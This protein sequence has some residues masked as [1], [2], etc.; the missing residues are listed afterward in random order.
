MPRHVRELRPHESARAFFGAELRHWRVRRHYSQDD[1]GRLTLHSGD[2]I[3]KVEKATRWPSEPLAQRCDLVL[4]TG[5]ELARLL[6]LVMAERSATGTRDGAGQLVTA[7]L[8]DPDVGAVARPA[9]Q[10]AVVDA[11]LDA[12]MAGCSAT[13]LVS[14]PGGFGKTT[15]A[16]QSCRDGRVVD[17]FNAL[18]WI[19]LG[20]DCG[21][22][23]ILQLAADL[24]ERLTR[25]RPVLSSTDQAG[26]TLAEALADRRILLVIDNV[27]T[28]NALA[29]FLLGGART[30]R[31]VTTRDVG[32]SRMPAA[33][34]AVPPMTDVQTA[35]LIS[36]GSV[37]P[38]R[39]AHALPTLA[40]A[41]RGWPLLASVLAGTVARDLTSGASEATAIDRALCALRDEGPEAFDVADA[42]R[43]EGTIGRVVMSSLGHLDDTLTFRGGESLSDRYL[44]LAIF[45][46]AVPIPVPVLASWWGAE[47]GWS[48]TAVRQFA[49][50]L[51]DRSLLDAYRAADDTLVLHDVFRACLTSRARR[52]AQDAHKS[53]VASARASAPGG[54]HDLDLT[55]PYLWRHLTHHLCEAG[56][57]EEVISLLSEPRYLITKLHAFGPTAFVDDVAALKLVTG[58]GEATEEHVA[59]TL[60]RAVQLATSTERPADTA[61]TMLVA[62]CW[63]G[64]L[65][66]P[67]ATELRSIDDRRF[68]VRWSRPREEH[69]D[70]HTGAITSVAVAANRI[71]SGGEDGT[72]RVWDRESGR[73][74]RVLRGHHGW[75]HAVT[76]SLPDD[77]VASAGDDHV[78]RLWTLSSGEPLGV[79]TGHG[80]RV[81]SLSIANG[82]RVLLSAG[83]DGAVTAWSVEQRAKL[84]DMSTPGRPLWAVDVDSTGAVVAAGGEDETVRLYDIAS[85]AL[86]AEADGHT[87]WVRTV[88][89]APDAPLLA[90]GSGDG[91]VCLWST[92][93]GSLTLLRRTRTRQ[94]VRSVALSPGGGVITSAGEAAQVDAVTAAGR[95]PCGE[96]PPTVD[97]IRSLA[98][99]DGEAV[100]GCEDGSIR[101]LRD[102]VSPAEPAV[103]SPGCGTVWSTAFGTSG[104]VAFLGHHDGRVQITRSGTGEVTSSFQVGTG[105]IWSLAATDDIVAAACGDGAVRVWD[106]AADTEVGTFTS[107]D[108][109]AWAV[110]VDPTGISLAVAS[111]TGTLSLWDMAT[112][113]LRW[114]TS[115]HTGRIR[116]LAFGPHGNTMVTGGAD[117]ATRVWDTA[118]GARTA[119][120]TAGSNWVRS[121]ALDRTGTRT[122]SGLGSGDITVRGVGDDT[123]PVHLFGHSGRIL[124][125][126]FVTDDRL[127]SAAADG[128]IRL[129]SISGQSQLAHVRVDASLQCAAIH[130]L[131]GSVLASSAT[132][133]VALDVMFGQE[134]T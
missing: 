12:G 131:T 88:A 95:V 25:E 96:L 93:N 97:W 129:W 132:G 23:R 37:A 49:R 128:T 80:K 74:V 90:S 60:L 77:L 27:W 103:F 10:E 33:T 59:A 118:T 22:G 99:H 112:R 73:L 133:V 26:F 19:E 41:C 20:P 104:H 62:L 101:L 122:A 134:G 13:V 121:V 7:W 35:Q 116:G 81:R 111:G 64:H 75:V 40:A 34:I 4:D 57:P 2:L 6:P 76:V 58:A 123:C 52:T 85:G 11:L 127:V 100:L 21:D 48:T 65:D 130:P 39:D 17:F 87:D 8:P 86:L 31:L 50:A 3:A 110:A 5:G 56:L 44:D 92:T 115:A 32:V 102:T 24:C 15:L 94:R 46:P 113:E 38:L 109:R 82:G 70:G 69:G 29:P 79:L 83:E 119:E 106:V 71:V 72:V 28:A 108:G 45:P 55:R 61:G 107:E 54:W 43:R 30:V 91:S 84:M 78:V 120:Q 66:S 47:H 67:Q 105:R 125:L 51:S 114:H 126:A 9:E 42:G 124:G 14:G 16:L 36:N 18:L 89:F 117:G 53:L 68:D 63:A 98:V 1:L